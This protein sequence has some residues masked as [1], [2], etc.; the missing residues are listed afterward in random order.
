MTQ[1]D[2]LVEVMARA[3]ATRAGEPERV[4]AYYHRCHAILDALRAAGWKITGP[5]DNSHA[6]LVTALR[7]ARSWFS[8]DGPLARKCDAALAKATGGQHG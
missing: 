6:E 7:E 4:G 3:I 2:K 8:K 5:D 1:D